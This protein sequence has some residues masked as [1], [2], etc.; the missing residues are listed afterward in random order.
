MY[1]NGVLSN[2]FNVALFDIFWNKWLRY[3]DMQTQTQT[4]IY[5]KSLFC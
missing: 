5:I 1:N 4:H 2:C 3:P